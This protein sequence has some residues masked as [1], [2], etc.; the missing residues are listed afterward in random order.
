M[1]QSSFGRSCEH[2]G[3]HMLGKSALQELWKPL[4]AEISLE[5]IESLPKVSSQGFRGIC[6]AQFWEKGG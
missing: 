2:V 3:G 4:G 5:L 6:H 1:T